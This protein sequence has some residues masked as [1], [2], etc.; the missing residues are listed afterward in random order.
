MK[1]TFLF[2]LVAA[3]L[4]ILQQSCVD[5]SYDDIDG[6]AHLP[7][8]TVRVGY[9]DTIWFDI[10]EQVP[11]WG[12]IN[13]PGYT[14]DDVDGSFQFDLPEGY[15]RFEVIEEFTDVF[16]DD[17]VDQV[18]FSGSDAKLVI[19]SIMCNMNGLD[20]DIVLQVILSG[21]KTNENDQQEIVKIEKLF[22][23]LEMNAEE[24]IELAFSPEDIEKMQYIKDLSVKAEVTINNVSVTKDLILQRHYVSLRSIRL[25]DVFF[26]INM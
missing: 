24:S 5:K 23:E 13:I 14:W 18:F 12:N 20:A 15:R 25:D 1:K 6:E 8:G 26:K 19:D 22:D 16:T 21:V 10:T 7:L 2:F 17:V 11:N 3:G 9:V 4:L